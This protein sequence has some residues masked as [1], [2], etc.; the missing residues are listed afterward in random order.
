MKNMTLVYA[1][2]TRFNVPFGIA[3]LKGHIEKNS[4]VKVRCL[5]LNAEMYNDLQ[6]GL[7]GGLIDGG[8]NLHQLLAALA[9]FR[10][11]AGDAFYDQRLYNRLI[12]G[13][14]K[15]VEQV[16][17]NFMRGYDT[18]AIRNVRKICEGNP[19]VIGFSCMFKDQIDPSLMLA[20]KIKKDTPGVRIVFGGSSVPERV[21]KSEFVDNVIH[22]EGEA[23]LLG[24]VRLRAAFEVVGGK[25]TFADFSDF[26]LN[27]Y[28]TPGPVVPLL[29]S[30]GCYWRKCAFCVH[31]SIY[32]AGFRTRN[33]E[34]VIDEIEHHVKNGVRYFMFVDEMIAPKRLWKLGIAIQRRGLD[35]AYSVMAK[36]TADFSNEAFE[37]MAESGCKYVMWGVESGCQRILDL[38]NK[39]TQVRY[40]GRSLRRAARAGI[41]NHVFMMAGFP[42]E[43]EY[44]YRE[45]L[46]FLY[47]HREVI[48]TV[49]W[50][51]FGLH[52]GSDVA[53]NPEKYSIR[54]IHDRPGELGYDIRVGM[55][56][57]EVYPIS[58]YYYKAF[59]KYLC[60][61]SPASVF[62]REHAL[63]H[64]ANE[65]KLVF[66]MGR[67]EPPDIA[68]VPYFEE[69]E[70]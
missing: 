24:L 52:K 16:A 11:D 55:R 57:H 31:H 43:T 21:E 5:D 25:D 68:D 56:Q 54:Q 2:R 62:M 41:K 42:T 12:K 38:M 6:D 7:M 48:H 22:G 61:F 59:V 18:F 66:N 44:E 19:E 8:S 58:L 1:P 70:K 28:P 49:H 51:R 37:Q 20:E 26:D 65:D 4:D 36:P 39:G 27:K 30:R 32:T 33:I 53:N 45:T 14:L 15:G 46:D 60:W 13:W 9:F 67:P 17:V 64:Y 23:G 63:F 3:L 69:T 35:I 34:A 10:G 40:I 29:T 47:R 50:G